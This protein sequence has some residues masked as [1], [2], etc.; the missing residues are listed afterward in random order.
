[1]KF[2]TLVAALWAVVHAAETEIEADQ[3]YLRSRNAHVPEQSSFKDIPGSFNLPLRGRIPAKKI[4]KET[5]KDRDA[6]HSKI[7]ADQ[8]FDWR[9][10]EPERYG[11]KN[12]Y[13]KCV[14]PKTTD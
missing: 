9:D 13:R 5:L 6:G 8:F 3:S 7:P 14:W 12:P 11:G 2:L 10:H 4:P 1:M